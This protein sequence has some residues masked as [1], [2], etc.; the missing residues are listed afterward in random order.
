MAWA[1]IQS[2]T[3]PPST[4]RPTDHGQDIDPIPPLVSSLIGNAT[5]RTASPPRRPVPGHAVNGAAVNRLYAPAASPARIAKQRSLTRATARCLGNTIGR[6][7][8]RTAK[9]PNSWS[10]T[11]REKKRTLTTRSRRRFVTVQREMA[12]H[13]IRKN[14]RNGAYIRAWREKTICHSESAS[15]RAATTPVAV[16]KRRDPMRNRAG[17]VSAPKTAAGSR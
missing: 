5:D 8:K 14:S 12:Q 10:N 16:P 13:A 6:R 9:I 1:A 3:I 15:I 4:A 7:A 11:A 2:P 17:M